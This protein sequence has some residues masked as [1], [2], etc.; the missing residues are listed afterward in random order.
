MQYAPQ[1]FVAKS[2]NADFSIGSATADVCTASGDVLIDVAT[3]S[4]YVVSAGGVLTSVSVHT[5]Q[6]N[7]T[8]L[9]TALEG[10]LVNILPQ[11]V[12]LHAIPMIGGLILKSGQ[13]IVYTVVGIG[14]TGSM[15]IAIPFMPLTTGAALM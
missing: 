13:K 11:K 12:L 7:Q 14:G 6:T 2:F 1:A 4:M 10:A 9:L 8:V 5:N 3:V 15:D